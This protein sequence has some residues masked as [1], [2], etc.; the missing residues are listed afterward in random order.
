MFV[1]SK[2]TQF[3]VHSWDWKATA[4]LQGIGDLIC[5]NWAKYQQPSNL[6][7]VHTGSDQEACVI[8]PIDMTEEQAQE[9]YYKA[10]NDSDEFENFN[11]A[12]I[13]EAIKELKERTVHMA[14]A[15]K[16]GKSYI[17]SLEPFTHETGMKSG[18]EIVAA[19][20]RR[21][22]E[23][24]GFSLLHDQN[25]VNCEL[26]DYAKFLLTGMKEHFPVNFNPE[27]AEKRFKR[28]HYDN[29]VKAAALLV[30]EIDRI[31]GKSKAF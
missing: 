17:T 13:E 19:E 8:G 31:N 29:L 9:T 7:E 22:I 1:K 24:E 16:R 14:V 21:Q 15:D 10:C 5:F 23:Q 27:W 18:I 20:R 11:R 26:E 28:S 3:A 2:T 6:V 25:Y 30:A 4:N 12:E